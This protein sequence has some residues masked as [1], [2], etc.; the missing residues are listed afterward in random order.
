MKDVEAMAV[1]VNLQLEARRSRKG[2]TC[3]RKARQDAQ[4]HSAAVGWG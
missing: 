3:M 4:Q 1:V 2:Q